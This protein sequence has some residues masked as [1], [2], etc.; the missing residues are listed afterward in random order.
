MRGYFDIIKEIVTGYWGEYVYQGLFYFALIIIFVLEKDL[1]RKHMYATYTMVIL[2]IIY[3]PI[4]IT[5]SKLYFSENGYASY[6]PRFFSTIPLI[7]IIAYGL[8]LVLNETKGIK[9]LVLTITISVMIAL[10]GNNI[11]KLECIKKADNFSKVPLEI[12][13]ITTMLHGEKEGD[14]TVAVTPEISASIRL[15][16][17]SLYMPYGRMA[18]DWGMKLLTDASAAEEIMLEAGKNGCDYIV[19]KNTSEWRDAFL[20]LGYKPVNYTLNY[21]IYKVEGVPRRVYTYNNIRQVIR[22]DYVDENENLYNCMHGYSTVEYE[23]DNVGNKICEMYYMADGKAYINES[24]FCGI[25]KE[26]NNRGQ[27][28]RY[29]YLDCNADPIMISSGYAMKTCEYNGIGEIKKEMYFDINGK[30]I[31]LEAGNYGQLM[32]YDEDGNLSEVSYINKEGNVNNTVYGY[33]KILYQYDLKG[34]KIEQKYFDQYGKPAMCYGLYNSIQWIYNTDGKPQKVLY[35]DVYGNLVLN[36]KGYAIKVYVYDDKQGEVQGEYYDA[37]GN[38][39]IYDD[40]I[41]GYVKKEEVKY[42]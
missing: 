35:K 42:E 12:Q 37:C 30:H 25:R 27:T 28:I 40:N 29:T 11:Y 5:V 20:N 2:I 13:G 31:A 14:I 32:K 24:G 22:I 7:C 9:K 6:Y 16:D 33:A 4:T 38:A 23:Y 34:N 21:L 10:G 36:K 18:S 1:M 39:L 8:V 26:Y 15:I 17:A 19:T 41:D 3:N